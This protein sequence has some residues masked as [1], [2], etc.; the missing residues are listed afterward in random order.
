MGICPLIEA[1]RSSP[2]QDKEKEVASEEIDGNITCGYLGSS[3][4]PKRNQSGGGSWNS[5]ER[6]GR[7]Q[8]DCVFVSQQL[9]MC[10]FSVY[11]WDTTRPAHNYQGG[12]RRFC[13]CCSLPEVGWWGTEG[14]F[15]RKK[16]GRPVMPRLLENA[17]A[18]VR[19]I[20]GGTLTPV[21]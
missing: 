18:D 16:M 2:K 17:V 14:N 8:V 1:M 11:P 3:S 5:M 6:T 9:W 10:V 12:H 20:F 13:E 4:Q 19:S 21:A 15:W 7:R